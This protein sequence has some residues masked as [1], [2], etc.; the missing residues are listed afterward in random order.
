[1]ANR[2]RVLQPENCDEVRELARRLFEESSDFR[3]L[4]AIALSRVLTAA[5]SAEADE[6]C[7]AAYG[8]R[9]PER[10]NSRNGYRTTH[11]KSG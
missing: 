7:G 4:G 6:L 5:M 2:E 9:S 11:V 10:V 8:R 3:E 1:M